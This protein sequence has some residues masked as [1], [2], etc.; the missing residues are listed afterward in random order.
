MALLSPSKATSKKP[1]TIEDDLAI[2]KGDA[3]KESAKKVGEKIG[4]TE[5]SVRY[6][7]NKLR[8]IIGKFEEENDREMTEKDLRAMHK[9]REEAAKK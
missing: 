1:F 7:V 2:V 6:R 3:A 4:R 5:Y 8:D 9:A